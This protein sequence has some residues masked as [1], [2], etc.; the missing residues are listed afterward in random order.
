VKTFIGFLLIAALCPIVYGQT[1]PNIEE[2]VHPFGSYDATNIDN[3][4]IAT[5]GLTVNIPLFSFPQRGNLQLPLV[6]TSSAKQW[7]VVPR[8]NSITQTCTASWRPKGSSQGLGLGMA[9]VIRDNAVGQVISTRQVNGQLTYFYQASLSDGSTHWSFAT[10]TSQRESVDATGMACQ[11]CQYGATA[12]ASFE[13]R[14]GHRSTT[15]GSNSVT[16]D[17]NGNEITM[18]PSSTDSMGRT[19]IY[20]NVLN[21]PSTDTSNC[22][23]K[24]P[25][26]SAALMTF[27]GPYGGNR[28]VKL[29][30]AIISINTAF[31]AVYQDQF[32]N[33]DPISEYSYGG[34]V[35]QSVMIYNGTSWSSSPTW[36]FEYNNNANGTGVT[37]FG[38][39]TKIVFPSG[40]SVSYGWTTNGTVCTQNTASPVSRWVTS[41]TLDFNNG[42][43]TATWNY[44]TVGTV[45]DPNGNQTVHGFAL[46]SKGCNLYEGGVTSYLGSEI[47]NHVIK[48]V[49]TDYNSIASPNDLIGD[50]TPLNLNVYPIRVT[51]TWPATAAFPSGK[52]SKVET[53]YGFTFTASSPYGSVITAN[54]GTPTQKREYDYGN[55]T[56]GALLRCTT[57]TYETSQNA[58]YQ[59]LNMLDLPYQVT[60]WSGACGTG[61]QMTQTT[62]HYDASALQASGAPQLDNSVSNYRGN[63]TS[64]AKWLNFPSGTVTSS[65]TYYDSGLPHTTQDPNGNLTT[66]TYGTTYDGAYLTQTT[67]PSTSGVNHIVGAGYDFNTG[68]VTSYTDQNNQPYGYVYDA[69]SRLTNASYPDGGSATLSY[70]NF[71]TVDETRTMNSTTS[72]S[73]SKVFDG[74]GRAIKSIGPDTSEVDTTYDGLGNVLTVTNPYQ[75]SSTGVPFTSY[76]YDALNRKVLQCQQDN[77]NN[78]PCEPGNSYL[79]W[80]Y[81]GADIGSYRDENGNTWSQTYDALGRMT[82]V[83]EPT[84]ASTNYTYSA[85]NDL[86]AV[87]Q[88]G[89]SGDTARTRSFYYDSLSRLLAANNP[90]TSS[91]ANPAS[92]TCEAGGPWSTCYSYD[93]NGNLQ[94]KTDNRNVTTTYHYDGLNR[95]LSKTYSGSGTTAAATAAATLSSCYLYDTS[96]FGTS[97]GNFTG[98]L[99][100]EWT[101]TGACPAAVPAA[102]YSTRRSILAYDP[103]GRVTSEQQ[104]NF[105]TCSTNLPYVATST[106]DFLGNELTYTNGLDNL[107]FTKTYDTAGRF[108]GET[109]TIGGVAGQDAILYVTGYT[110]AGAIQSMAIDSDTL[111][112]KSYDTRLRPTSE[113]AVHQ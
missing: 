47:N 27:P 33:A 71:Y 35:L 56:P 81:G 21:T 75:G 101:Q 6:L 68:L 1:N 25:P 91:A 77:G 90:E 23:G 63:V 51:T 53:D 43:P 46:L 110:P 24:L 3:V 52:V 38:D 66:Y 103:M 80:T 82:N 98:R 7:Y 2:G 67:L 15:I 107:N 64:V 58:T 17:P 105:G 14:K 13:D 99:T 42:T 84:G 79:Q 9:V 37:N 22:T 104:C 85:R 57:Y 11:N 28:L 54:Y 62:Y 100:S 83:T 65:T 111:V 40:G 94:T 88:M 16:E 70:P 96:S 97:P 34:G 59:T 20:E 55:G 78:T 69:L 26:S 87:S 49:Q 8:C 19:G 89:L 73:S 112:T 106:Y 31:N 18:F 108:Q 32:A 86:T 45:T 44:D 61:V 50:G 113:T 12:T 36:T 92:L 95:L 74:L 93:G 29:C 41:R 72:L 4:N 39:I 48:T 109:G 10:S 76:S 30:Y 5:G 102:G 60:T